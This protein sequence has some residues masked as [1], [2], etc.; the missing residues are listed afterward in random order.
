[1][2]NHSPKKWE[3]D[4]EVYEVQPGQFIT[5]LPGIVEKCNSNEIT[6]QKVRTAL[7]R[8]E[9]FGFLTG[10]ST[11]K[12]RLI[13]IV[14]WRLYQANDEEDNS[15]D[16]RHLTGNN[17]RITTNK[18]EK[19]DFLTGELT[20]KNSLIT[21]VN[22]QF[23]QDDG[24]DDNRQLNRHLTGTQQADN[25]QITPREEYKEYKNIKNDN[26]VNLSVSHN[27]TPKT[28]PIFTPTDKNDG[29]TIC[30]FISQLK[31]N[32]SY[33]SFVESNESKVVDEIISLAVDLVL[34]RGDVVIGNRQYPKSLV[35]DT[36]LKMRYEHIELIKI[37]LDKLNA[38]Q[39]IHNPKRYTQSI[40]FNIALN[41]EAEFKSFFN[42]HGGGDG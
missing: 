30:D 10:K 20:D 28:T 4:G 42:A 11:N 13:T 3:F 16:N 8:F 15:Q 14:N 33:E 34:T 35:V 23:Y 12:N 25:R 5:S 27:H 26:K 19:L 37:K 41:Y 39:N 18:N 38:D 21:T 40:I 2:A 24:R 36:L 22:Q 6:A 32:I 31:D 17:Q 29:L 7:T 9:K 1:M